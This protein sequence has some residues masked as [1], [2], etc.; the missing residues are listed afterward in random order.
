MEEAA[1]RCY[2]AKKHLHL[3]YLV[4][5]EWDLGLLYT[6]LICRR[7]TEYNFV[8]ESIQLFWRIIQYSRSDERGMNLKQGS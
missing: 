1:H 5:Q 8:S 2:T 4:Y 7:L 3:H 6:R